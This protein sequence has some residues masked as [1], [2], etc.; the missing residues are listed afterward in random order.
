MQLPADVAVGGG[1]EQRVGRSASAVSDVC[2]VHATTVTYENAPRR[3]RRETRYL[4]KSSCG[5][6]GPADE[7][8]TVKYCTICFLNLKFQVIRRRQGPAGPT[9]TG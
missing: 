3:N 6:D 8:H 2:L 7:R 1:V 5:E 4:T 9:V